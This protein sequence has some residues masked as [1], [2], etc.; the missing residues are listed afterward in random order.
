MCTGNSTTPLAFSEVNVVEI[1]G[2]GRHLSN[3]SGQS[4]HDHN[5]LPIPSALLEMVVMVRYRGDLVWLRSGDRE[6]TPG[7]ITR[8][9]TRLPI[10]RRRPSWE[11]SP[12]VSDPGWSSPAAETPMMCVQGWFGC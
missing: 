8:F 9:M 10:V 11:S 2:Q 3:G 1:V 4:F 12:R 7:A 6:S 5:T